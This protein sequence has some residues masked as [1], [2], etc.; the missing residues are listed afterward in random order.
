MVFIDDVKKVL[1]KSWAV[2]FSVLSALLGT[3][4]QFQAQLPMIQGF[5]PA[6]WY[7]AASITCA[8]A[9]TL[10]RVIHQEEISGR[11]E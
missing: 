6:Q 9:A 4:A 2:R 10:A 7:A 11:K 3:I 1:L 5:V 8:V